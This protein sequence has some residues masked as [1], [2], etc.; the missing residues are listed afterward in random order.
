MS[1]NTS[2]AQA[3]NDKYRVTAHITL[4]KHDIISELIRRLKFM[5]W[6]HE[7]IGKHYKNATLSI[8][9]NHHDEFE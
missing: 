6:T 7:L 5:N 2:E 3:N 9:K 8:F 4:K 1:C